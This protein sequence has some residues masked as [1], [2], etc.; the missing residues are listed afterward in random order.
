MIKKLAGCVREYTWIA[1]LAPLFMIGEVV[2]EVLVPYYMADLVD[3][4]IEKGDI[5]VIRHMGLMLILLALASMLCGCMGAITSSVASSGFAANLRHD[6]YYN[7][8]RFSFSNIDKF[9]TGG[10]VT[11]MTTDVTNV[12]MAFTMLM[13]MAVRAPA[14]IVFALIMALKINVTLATLFIYIIP[15]LGIGMFLIMRKAM[16]MF[17]KMF[18]I[19]DKLNNTVQENVRGIKVVKA[20]A[21]EKEETEKFKNVSGELFSTSYGAER[22]MALNGPLMQT[23]MYTTMLLIAWIGAKLIVAGDL[24]TGQLMSINSYILQILMSLM[25]LSMMLSMSSMAFAAGRR[26]TE[27]LDEEPDIVDAPNAQ[28]EVKDGS[29]EFDNVSFG[30][31][32]SADCLSGISFTAE[33]GQVIGILG[34][35]GSGKSSLVQLLP[36]LYEVRGGSVKVGGTDVRNIS[37]TALRSAVSM[38]LQKNVLFSGTVGE[39]LRWG[40]ENAKDEDLIKALKYAQAYEF[41]EDKGGLDAVVEQG[42]AN[43]SGGQQQRLCIARALAGSPKILIMDD[44]TSAVDTATESKIRQAFQDELPGTTRIIIA[45]RVSSVKDADKIIVLDNGKIDAIGTHE[46]LLAENKIY[47]EILQY[48]QKGG[49]FDAAE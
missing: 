7:I 34:G 39:N 33:P 12:Q 8:Q 22:I 21:R 38:V 11:R 47:Q 32:E 5:S 40:N 45:Q 10:L 3:L 15:V 2:L 28:T 4:G 27:V 19:F 44:S 36:R 35:T 16:P 43:F 29:I 9:S 31:G 42:G 49:D 25:M 30:Y 48:Q 26:I 41:I 20:F 6:M 23:C 1:W 13:R 18:S 17:T 46:Q 24:T 14:T 37:L